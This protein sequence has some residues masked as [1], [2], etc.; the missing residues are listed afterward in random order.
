MA[1]TVDHPSHYAGNG[2][3]VI[4]AI[5]AWELNFHLGNAIKYIARAGKKGDRTEDLQKAAWY[6]Q[7]EI[8]RARRASPREHEVREHK[9]RGRRVRAYRRG[10]RSEERRVG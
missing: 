4:D 10:E 5:E 3:E 9:R 7:R 8:E 2:I 1:G 6:L